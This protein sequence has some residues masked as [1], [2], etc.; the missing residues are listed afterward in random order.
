[1]VALERILGVEKQRQRVVD[2]NRREVAVIIGGVIGKTKHVGEKPSCG[3]LVLR[4]HNGVVE[5][6]RHRPAPSLSSRAKGNS[7]L[8]RARAGCPHII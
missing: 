2:A 6:D 1:M 3:S 8:A 7:R 5:H 4:R